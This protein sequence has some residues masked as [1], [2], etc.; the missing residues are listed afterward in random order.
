M[1]AEQRGGGT[2]QNKVLRS[3]GRFF[4]G[5]G[6]VVGTPSGDARGLVR[7]YVKDADTVTRGRSF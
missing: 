5:T 2:M 3:I 7:V 4:A 6:D 1:G